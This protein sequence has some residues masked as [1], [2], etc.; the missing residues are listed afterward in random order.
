VPHFHD[1][2]KLTDIYLGI[3]QMASHEQC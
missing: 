2:E 1:I 3:S